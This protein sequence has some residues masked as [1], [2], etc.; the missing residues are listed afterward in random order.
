MLS[1]LF[2]FILFYEQTGIFTLA[3]YHVCFILCFSALA[4][5]PFLFALN[6]PYLALA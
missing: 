5:V 2:F 1:P 6:D 4:I 3:Y